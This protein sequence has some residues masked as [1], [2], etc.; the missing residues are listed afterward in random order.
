MTLAEPSKLIS[1]LYSGL[2]G[3]SSK[4]GI[5]DSICPSFLSHMLDLQQHSFACL[6][7]LHVIS[8]SLSPQEC[9]PGLSFLIVCS[10]DKTPCLAWLPPCLETHPKHFHMVC[11]LF[12]Q[13]NF[14]LG[15]VAFKLIVV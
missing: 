2:F 3:G 4:P 10:K 14:F 12:A 1:D 9:D 13:L 6:K 8:F 15:G 7:T 11:S 5:S